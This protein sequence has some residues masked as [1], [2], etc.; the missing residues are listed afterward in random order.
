MLSTNR[1]W[2]FEACAGARICWPLAG[3]HWLVC[4]SYEYGI[5]VAV[6]WHDCGFG[7]FSLCLLPDEPTPNF[8]YTRPEDGRDQ[9]PADERFLRACGVRPPDVRD[10]WRMLDRR[11]EE[12]SV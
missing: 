4:V 5:P 11:P 7:L 6:R 3:M 9:M 2:L 12:R 1:G 10:E 8:S